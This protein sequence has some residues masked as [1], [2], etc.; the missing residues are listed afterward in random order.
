MLGQR[1]RKAG[2]SIR[3]YD[4]NTPDQDAKTIFERSKGFIF[5]MSPSYDGTM[6]LFSYMEDVTAGESNPGDAF[7]IWEIGVDGAGLRQLTTGP[8]HDGSPAYLPDGRIVF[9]S[10]RMQSFAVCQD[11]L[12]ATLYVM[13]GNGENLKRLEFSTLCDTTPFVMEDGSILF[14]RWEYQDKNIFSVQGLWTINPDGSRVQLFYGNTVTIPNSIY[15][16]KQIPGTRK[17]LAVMAAHHHPPIGGIAIIDR[18]KGLESADAIRSLT[19]EVPYAPR[20]GESW[21][22]ETNGSWGPGDVFHPWTY[23]DP[24]PISENLFLVS[25]GGAYDGKPEKYSL[26]L[27]NDQGEKSQI[28]EAPDAS[29]FNPVPLRKRPL[30]HAFPGEY[31]G[32]T[33]C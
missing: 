29:C 4:P 3:I 23:T 32:E 28:Y 24:Y 1:P 18:D 6:L 5:D 33:Y 15:G 13:D 17:V 27:L 14:G 26:Y 2:S 31:A 8:F 10:T 12:A 7:H 9:T 20:T 22:H 30:T 21:N 11:Y 25:Y 19:P 16:A